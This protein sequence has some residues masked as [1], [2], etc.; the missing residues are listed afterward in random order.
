MISCHEVDFLTAY[1]FPSNLPDFNYYTIQKDENQY[2][3]SQIF[4]LRVETLIVHLPDKVFVGY[5]IKN[6]RIRRERSDHRMRKFLRRI[7]AYTP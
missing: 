1:Y 6:L 7:R 3:F 2:V 4:R 5:H